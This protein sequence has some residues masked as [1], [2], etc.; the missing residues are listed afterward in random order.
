MTTPQ[1][2]AIKRLSQ[3]LKNCAD[4]GL[5]IMGM[6]GSLTAYDAEEYRATSEVTDDAHERM[7]LCHEHYIEHHGAYG[8]SGGW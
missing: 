8:G 5:V 7:R 1:K 6:D 4:N 3:A 2:Q